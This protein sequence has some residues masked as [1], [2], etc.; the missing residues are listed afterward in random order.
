MYSYFIIVLLLPPCILSSYYDE[1]LS[2]YHSL[3]LAQDKVRQTRDMAQYR[4]TFEWLRQ[5]TSKTTKTKRN[6][7]KKKTKPTTEPEYVSYEVTVM[8]T[9][10]PLNPGN[11]NETVFSIL[12]SEQREANKT[13]HK[14]YPWIAYVVHSRD[15]DQPFLCSAACIEER[16]FITAARCLYRAKVYLTTVVH[17]ESKLRPIAFVVPTKNTKQLFDDVGFI[18]VDRTSH[19]WQTVKLYSAADNKNFTRTDNNYV[20]LSTMGEMAGTVVGYVDGSNKPAVLY[21][22]NVFMSGF[23]CQHFYN[24]DILKEPKY[25]SDNF[26]VPCYH[27]CN[28]WNGYS[29]FNCLKWLAGEGLAVLHQE[30]KKLFGV[31]TW[32]GYLGNAPHVPLP[33]GMAIPNS[34]SF[35]EDLECARK[36]KNA[37]VTTN[38]FAGLCK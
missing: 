22:A 3:L 24:V 15:R 1:L 23:L 25:F 26:F 12:R 14:E 27:T 37:P 8:P 32:G 35:R 6:K 19:N 38:S 36:I 28:L 9:K 16:I 7:T 34:A 31:A 4:P 21:E 30:S 13:S 2:A 29:K 18:I 17:Q 11:M 5:H 10:L 20:W 33:V